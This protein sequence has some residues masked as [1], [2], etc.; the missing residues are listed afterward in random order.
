MK[1]TVDLSVR[2]GEIVLRNPIILAPGPLGRRP[3]SMKRFAE[4]G[5][6]AVSSKTLSL[7]PWKGNPEPKRVRLPHG[8]LL[9]AEGAPNIG[10]EAFSEQMKK[11]KSKIRDSQ[12]IISVVGKTI[13]EFISMAV[14][15]EKMGADIIDLDI[16]CPNVS[17][18]GEVD[19]WQKDLGLIETLVSGVKKA[20]KVPLWIKFISAY[21][22][23]LSIA[24]TLEKA[25]ADAVVPFVSIGAM[26]IDIET[27]RPLLGCRQ[28]VGVLTGAPLKHAELKAVA[29]VCRTVNVPVIATGGCSSGLDMIEYL[30]AGARAVE[31]HTVFMHEGAGYVQQMI[32]QMTEFLREKGIS[33]IEDLIGRTLQ[34]LPKETFSFWYSS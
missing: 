4:A 33:R 6:G 24:K 13:E 21:G 27:G 34:Y 3:L 8:A 25:G 20:V 5:C 15:A 2:I 22:S 14:E 19:S 7:Q 11:T 18:K 16:T 12:V 1:G 26:A 30:M 29:D 31:I 17:D 10:V 28:R 23:L 9:N 32:S